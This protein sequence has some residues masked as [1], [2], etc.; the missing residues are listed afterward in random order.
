[1]KSM[2]IPTFAVLLVL[3]AAGT[4]F[5]GEKAEDARPRP[6]GE[7]AGKKPE[8]SKPEPRP[9]ARPAAR[10]EA[11]KAEPAGPDTGKAG[12]GPKVIVVP[13]MPTKAPAV[14]RLAPGPLMKPGAVELAGVFGFVYFWRKRSEG[15][16]DITQEHQVNLSLSPF[17]GVF[18]W[19]GLE[20][21]AYLPVEV[22]FASRKDYDESFLRFGFL[23]APAY[24][25]RMGG[26]GVYGFAEL[27]GGLGY[28]RATGEDAFGSYNESG[29]YLHI[30]LGL[31]VKVTLKRPLLLRVSLEPM[32]ERQKFDERTLD[33]V[34]VGLSVGLSGIL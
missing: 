3:C 30:G 28:G 23:L 11:R 19:R 31:G 15:R 2:R 1:M 9:A 12:E 18:V 8:S 13:P 29:I 16:D 24:N 21:G 14:A 4:S 27:R 5:A 32:F 6:A 22:V 25:F 17:V 7:T 33:D 20:L 34:G 10:P 26:S